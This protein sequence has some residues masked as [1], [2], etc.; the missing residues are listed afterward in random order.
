[1]G[2]SK[3]SWFFSS[4]LHLKGPLTLAL[5]IDST[6]FEDNSCLFFS[7]TSL[8]APVCEFWEGQYDKHA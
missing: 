4:H 6:K 2:L 7:I 1:M 8:Q 3:V 5:Q